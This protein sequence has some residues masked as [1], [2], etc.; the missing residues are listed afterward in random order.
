MEMKR[1]DFIRGGGIAALGIGALPWKAWSEMAKHPLAGQTLP[2]W[3][4]GVFRI[5]TLYTG[6]S[7]ATFLTF[8]DKDRSK[9]AGEPWLKDVAPESFVCAHT[10]VDVAPD[11]KTYTLMFVD[12]RDE[13]RTV[14]GAYDFETTSNG[15]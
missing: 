6:G 14:L 3:K 5:A 10:V 8:P 7:E 12:A 15:V 9:A 4:K 11:G 13:K 1:R 2:A